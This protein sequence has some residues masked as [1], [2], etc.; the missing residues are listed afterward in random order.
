MAIV[1][2]APGAGL[3]RVFESLGV[4]AV[5]PGG[6]TMNPSTQEI[7]KAIEGLNAEKVIQAGG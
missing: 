1:V 6:Q 2:V 5:V 4:G 7:L 3:A